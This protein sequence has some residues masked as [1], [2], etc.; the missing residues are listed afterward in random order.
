M[1][2]STCR[3]AL[4][5]RLDGEDAGVPDDEID[6]HLA[7][8]SDCA[9]WAEAAAVLARAVERTPAPSV[10][11]NPAVLASLTAPPE[12]ERRPGLLSVGEWRALLALFAVAQ[13]V[14]SFPGVLLH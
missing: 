9:E 1:R 13:L 4:S 6:A 11:L 14:V 7:W 12:P 8:C 2:C 10:P 3:E 5:A